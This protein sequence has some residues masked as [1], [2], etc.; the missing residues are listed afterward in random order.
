MGARSIA[1]NMAL[2][3]PTWDSSS[4]TSTAAV[5]RRPLSWNRCGSLFAER[6]EIGK[7]A[8][9]ERLDDL[10]RAPGRDQLGD[11]RA[12]RRAGLEA[13]CPAHVQQESFQALYW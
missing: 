7:T 4:G 6:L 8:E 12:R 5:S 10:R 3:E 13:I 2:R 1:K 9:G 11:P